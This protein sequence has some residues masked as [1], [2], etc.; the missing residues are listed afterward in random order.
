MVRTGV[1][2]TPLTSGSSDEDRHGGVDL[3]CENLR[4][5]IDGRPLTN[6][7]DWARGY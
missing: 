6:V 7:I 3:F 2:I 1:L 5:Y 4:K